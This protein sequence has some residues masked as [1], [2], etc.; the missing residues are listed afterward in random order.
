MCELL[1]LSEDDVTRD[2][3]A[4]AGVLCAREA[5]ELRGRA[6]DSNAIG[7]PGLVDANVET[8]VR[9]ASARESVTRWG[10]YDSYM[11]D[12]GPAVAAV[13]DEYTQAE[14]SATQFDTYARCPARLFYS[15]VLRIGGQEEL[16]PDIA[17]NVRG[18]VLHGILEKF[19]SRGGP[20]VGVDEY[21]GPNGRARMLECA[22]M[23]FEALDEQYPNL[24]WEEE[25]R[26]LVL[27]LD[28]PDG[29]QGL[30]A[31][32]LAAEDAQRGITFEGGYTR[33]RYNEVAFGASERDDARVRLDAHVIPRAS[34]DGDIRIKGYVDRVD[35][36][37]ETGRFVVFDYKTGSNPGA[38]D[39]L[40]GHSFQLAIYMDALAGREGLAS[41]A[42]GVFY[43]VQD[44]TKVRRKDPIAR[45]DL[46]KGRATAGM[47]GDDAFAQFRQVTRERVQEIEEH[48]RHGRFPVTART[49]TQARC[50]TCDY[51]DVCRVR[52]SRRRRMTTAQPHY[53]P[54][55]FEPAAPVEPRES[56]SRPD[57]EA[58]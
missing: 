18:I 57:A 8:L 19:F 54:R 15:H 33:G 2:P 36:D 53:D 40:N 31:G 12:G 42:G 14:L 56:P 6:E 47:L 29:P 52:P 35:A 50:P 55:P 27:G 22:R 41:P 25:K 10:D 46:A 39:A 49:P 11:E 58:S 3:A 34:G 20:G 28:D 30:L 24:Y 9:L 51:R 21:D 16:E 43:S 48:I 44:P 23:E 5:L 4:D 7:A 26:A 37:A 17:P 1:G 32:F 38:R 45:R 13:L